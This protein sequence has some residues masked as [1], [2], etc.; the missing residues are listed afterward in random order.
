[1]Q[2]AEEDHRLKEA[3]EKRKAA[4]TKQKRRDDLAALRTRL[5]LSP[6]SAR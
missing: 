1:M 5:K 3:R 2:Q 4:E 6:A